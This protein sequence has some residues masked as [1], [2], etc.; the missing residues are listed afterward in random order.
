MVIFISTRAA[1]A[2]RKTAA[3]TVEF[4]QPGNTKL[5]RYLWQQQYQQQQQQPQQ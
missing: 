2:A 5:I 4:Q 1:K 3:T